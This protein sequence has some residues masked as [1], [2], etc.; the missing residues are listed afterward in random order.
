MFEFAEECFG[1]GD[2]FDAS[3]VSDHGGEVGDGGPIINGNEEDFPVEL[4]LVGLCRWALRESKRGVEAEG[5][6]ER[7]HLYY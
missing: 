7:L 3:D 6:E 2:D 5:E 4:R 1:R